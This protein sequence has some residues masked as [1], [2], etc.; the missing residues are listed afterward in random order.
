MTLITSVTA[1][2][3][4]VTRLGALLMFSLVS[5]ATFSRDGTGCLADIQAGIQ[6]SQH[7]SYQH[8]LIAR[9]H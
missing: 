4:P 9:Y 6:K 5:Q 2:P 8:H 3:V 7:S 1:H